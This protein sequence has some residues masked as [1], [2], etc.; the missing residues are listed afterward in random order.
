M[1]GSGSVRCVG[2][3][4]FGGDSRPQ[5]ESW[6]SVRR[7][8]EL[9]PRALLPWRDWLYARFGGESHRHKAIPLDMRQVERVEESERTCCQ[10]EMCV[11]LC[12]CV[13][14]VI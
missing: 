6:K 5:A 8:E 1:L 11:S 10:W 13:Y 4:A 9:Q 12:F 14:S 7:P 3:A 2:L